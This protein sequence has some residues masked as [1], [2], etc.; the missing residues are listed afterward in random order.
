[1]SEAFTVFDD[2]RVHVIAE[3][4]D[5]STRDSDATNLS[6]SVGAVKRPIRQSRLPAGVGESDQLRNAWVDFVLSVV[7]GYVYTHG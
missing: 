6:T 1:L 4:A 5:R 3:E 7:N 2:E